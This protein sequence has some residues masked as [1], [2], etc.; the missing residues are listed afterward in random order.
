MLE[1]AR[2][3]H[4]ERFVHGPPVVGSLPAAVWINPP[5]DRSQ[6]DLHLADARKAPLPGATASGDES[7][8]GS[9]IAEGDERSELVLDAVVI[10]SHSEPTSTPTTM[11]DPQ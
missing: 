1:A 2:C 3:A 7:A 11:E 4:P 10:S 8:A 9:R 6:V 5:E